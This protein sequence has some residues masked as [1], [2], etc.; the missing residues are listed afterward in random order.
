MFAAGMPLVVPTW[1]LESRGRTG[2][3]N[4]IIGFW[5]LLLSQPSL[6][7]ER[8]LQQGHFGL[9][10]V[11]LG[12]GVCRSMPHSISSEQKTRAYKK[13]LR[14]RS[15]AESGIQGQPSCLPFKPAKWY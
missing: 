2:I 14:T 9:E 8:A 7:P 15:M 11:L 3:S 13:V 1:L 12:S 10:V 4:V 5:V 6:R